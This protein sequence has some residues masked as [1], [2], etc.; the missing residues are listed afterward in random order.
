MEYLKVGIILN[1][2]KKIDFKK[3]EKELLN[4]L[5]KHRGKHGEYDCIVPGSGGKDSCYA[6][7]VLKFKYGMNP[8][9]VT[10]P[11]I[12]YTDYGYKNFKNWIKS[13]KFSN[14]SAKRDEGTMIKLTKLAVLNLMHPFQTFMLGQKKL[15]HPNCIKKEYTI[16]FLW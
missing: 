2:K 4:L 12:L 9:T 11:P 3:R 15:S 1:K 13:G 16:S 6:S 14:I 7:H 5:E 10:W 8:L